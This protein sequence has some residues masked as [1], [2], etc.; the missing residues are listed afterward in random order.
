MA[1]DS[2]TAT[3][4][5]DRKQVSANH[6]HPAN[7]DNT[8]PVDV[9]QNNSE[10]PGVSSV[11]SR[12]DHKHKHPH[13]QATPA[14][15]TTVSDNDS[16]DDHVDELAARVKVNEGD[17]STVAGAVGSLAFTDL[18]DTPGTLGA[19]NTFV[20]VNGAGSALEFGAVTGDPFFEAR[21]QISSGGA[22]FVDFAVTNNAFNTCEFNIVRI[23]QT[24]G[25]VALNTGSHIFTLEAGTYKI[26]ARIAGIVNT[27]NPGGSANVRAWPGV[28]FLSGD[29][30]PPLEGLGVRHAADG[31]GGSNV[32]VRDTVVITTTTTFRVVLWTFIAAAALRVPTPN[33]DGPLNNQVGDLNGQFGDIVITKK[34]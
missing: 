30:L 17:I 24:G 26:D 21:W 10:A 20:K 19:A 15:W 22:E 3:P 9:D 31:V 7:V 14:D 6:A 28:E 16:I 29:A 5:T 4:G 32:S 23:D 18:A 13:T 34:G 33:A 27:T 1:S 11:Y 8:A 2:G 25:D 12:N